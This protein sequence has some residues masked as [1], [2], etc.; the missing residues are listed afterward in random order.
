MMARSNTHRSAHGLSAASKNSAQTMRAA[1]CCCSSPRCSLALLAARCSLRALHHCC[2]C[3][4]C[5]CCCWALSL[6][7]LCCVLCG[8]AQLDV[9]RSR[10]E[11]ERAE[12]LLRV[13]GGGADAADHQRLGVLTERVLEQ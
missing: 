7:A 5:C 4:C 2:C 3:C 10:C 6:F 8:L 9:A 12:R 11:V 13:E 1:R